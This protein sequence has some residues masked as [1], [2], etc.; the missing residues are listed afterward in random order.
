MNSY[1]MTWYFIFCIII[2]LV[3]ILISIVTIIHYS[4]QCGSYF[5]STGDLSKCFDYQK[6]LDKVTG[7]IS[8]LRIIYKGKLPLLPTNISHLIINLKNVKSNSN[9]VSEKI[10]IKLTNSTNNYLQ[11]WKFIYSP[12]YKSAKIVCN[13]VGVDVNGVKNIGGG[14][15]GNE[16]LELNISPSILQFDIDSF[17][18]ESE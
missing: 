7:N 3:S 15:H 8:D 12:L 13:L 2:I 5:K 1:D 14:I 10:R 18:G 11:N 9:I 17:I 4:N 16:I 6:K